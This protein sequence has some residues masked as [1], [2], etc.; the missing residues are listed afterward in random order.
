MVVIL[1]FYG[2]LDITF[3]IKSSSE[4]VRVFDVM[5]TDTKSMG[6]HDIG[7]DSGTHI[8]WS[9]VL[10]AFESRLDPTD[11]D[12]RVRWLNVYVF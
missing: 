9:S 12:C 8:I 4:C 11:I 3:E 7:T 2:N 10:S 6:R 1:T 5:I